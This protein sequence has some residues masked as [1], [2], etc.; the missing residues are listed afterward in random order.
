MKLRLSARGTDARGY[1]SS[2]TL[3]TMR[4]EDCSK[5]LWRTPKADDPNHG[6]ASEAGIMRRLEKGQSIRLQDQVNHP[7]LFRTPDAGCARGALSDAERPGSASFSDAEGERFGQ[8][9]QDA[10]RGDERDEPG[11]WDKF[12]LAYPALSDADLQRREELQPALP[13]DGERAAFGSTECCRGRF[14]E[15]IVG[16]VADG[17]PPSLDRPGMAAFIEGGYWD[18][19]PDIPRTA[20]GVKNRVA[21]LRA[22]GNAVVPTQAH[23]IF[24]A[25]A[26]AERGD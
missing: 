15:P 24:R 16:G 23:P 5:T 4:T 6:S 14:L 25:I 12:D 19:E 13:E 20:K 26:G 21:R 10:G 3:E 2:R 9:T 11:A 7:G 22:L 17:L 1:S 8:G 18:I